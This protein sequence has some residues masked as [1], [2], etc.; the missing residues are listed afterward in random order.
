[1]FDNFQLD[2]EYHC[3]LKN[4]RINDIFIFIIVQLFRSLSNSLHTRTI[5]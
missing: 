5:I 3:L 1:M 2:E 4:R